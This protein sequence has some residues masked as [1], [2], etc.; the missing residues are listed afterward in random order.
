MTAAQ[1][2]KFLFSTKR[3]PA[4]ISK[5]FIYWKEA[6]TAFKKHQASRC[7]MEANE[8][9]LIPDQVCGCIGELLSQQHHDEKA[10]NRRMLMIILQNIRF[11][12][13]QGLSLRDSSDMEKYSNFMQLLILRGEDCVAVKAWVNKKK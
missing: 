1:E 12:A 3:D 8:A 6:I 2:R 5:G 4:F 9:M 13:C 10:K 7:H 11:L